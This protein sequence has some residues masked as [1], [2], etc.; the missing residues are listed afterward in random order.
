MFSGQCS[1]VLDNGKD[2]AEVDLNASNLG[3]FIPEMVWGIQF[4]HSVDN[5]LLVFASEAYDADD[6]LSDYSAFVS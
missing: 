2:R 5:V 3:L 6:Y 4:R 1:V